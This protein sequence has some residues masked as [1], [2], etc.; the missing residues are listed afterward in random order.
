M[1]LFSNLKTNFINAGANV[2]S[3]FNQLA[4]SA[5]QGTNTVKSNPLS[6]LGI[7][8]NGSYNPAFSRSSVSTNF[9]DGGGVSHA[10]NIG[11][12]LADIEWSKGY[13]WDVRI[14]PPPP[15]PF[16]RNNYGI[17]VVDVQCDFALFGGSKSVNISNATYNV[18]FSKTLFDIK[19]T[20]LDD[21]KGTMEQYFEEWQ[22]SVYR[23]DDGGGAIN[24]LSES[25]RQIDITKLDSQKKAIFTRSYL[26]Y[27]EQAMISVNNSQG[28]VRNFGINLVVAGYL[29]KSTEQAIVRE[30]RAEIVNY[31]LRTS[32]AIMGDNTLSLF[33]R[34]K[35]K[36]KKR[37]DR[38]YSFRSEEEREFFGNGDY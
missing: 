26:V 14:D 16:D 36:L 28:A 29:G 4:N 1:S 11:Q 38:D 2:A 31:D 35:N 13:N 19:L 5:K 32:A 30:T 33:E 37:D 12:M 10:P 15:A 17:P 9:S 18:P 27:P 7:I 22:N 3:R 8:L 23:W 34:M 24:Y 20:L 6:A 21:E 25:V